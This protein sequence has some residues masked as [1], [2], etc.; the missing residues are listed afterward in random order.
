MAAPEN[1]GTDLSI[2][3]LHAEIDVAEIETPTFDD[4]DLEEPLEVESGLEYT[5]DLAL[6]DLHLGT[7][8]INFDQLDDA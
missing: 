2:L 6:D 7:A 4:Y 1:I 5:G 8:E 3:D